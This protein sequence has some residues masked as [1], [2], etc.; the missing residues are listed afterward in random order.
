LWT[1]IPKVCE[2]MRALRGQPNRGVRDFSS[3]M[4][5]M[6][7][8]SGPFDPGFVGHDVDE[9]SRRYLPRTKA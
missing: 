8:L 7:V 5:R 4:A 1:S 9:N 2:M 6:S 3:T